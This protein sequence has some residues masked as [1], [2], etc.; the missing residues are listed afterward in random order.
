MPRSTKHRRAQPPR[1]RVDRSR[2]SSAPPLTVIGSVVVL[3]VA[4]AVAVVALTRAPAHRA[5]TVSDSTLEQATVHASSTATQLGRRHRA[6]RRHHHRHHRPTPQPSPTSSASSTPAP[7]TQS[8]PPST[9]GGS[10][11]T[12][13]AVFAA[14]SRSWPNCT[15]TG[16]PAGLNLR[17]LNSPDPTGNGNSTATT[18]TKSGTVISGVNL[19]GSIDV[20]ANNVTIE[21]SRINARNWWGINLRTGYSGLRVLHCTI[22]GLP[23]K[24]PDNGA[25]DYG[26]SSAGGQVEI[27]WSDISEFGDAISL[28][29]GDIH[30]NYVHNLQSFIPAGA[31]TYNHDD[32]LISDGGS[33]LTIDHNT[34]LDQFSPQKGASA[35]IGLFN[36]GSPVTNVTVHDNFIA[37]GA[38]ALYPGGG[39][40]SKNIVITD[41]VFSTIYWSGGG[42]YG[43]DASSYWHTGSGNT[44]SGNVWADGPKAGREVQP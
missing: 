37:G 32:A 29:T 38:Y 26:V 39:S 5:A 9:E 24:G 6:G 7:P 14:G 43:P 22:I 41:N 34:M 19:T 40:S 27:G 2:R 31:S 8:P 4:L 25:E 16:V 3:C 13:S 15:N 21:N 30:D 17:N 20:Y 12:S 42:Y 18:I 10:C 36:D 35:S 23:G 33:G 28:G 11:A 44:W 1:S